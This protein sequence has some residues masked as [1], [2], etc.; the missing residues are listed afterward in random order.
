MLEFENPA[1]IQAIAAL[2]DLT[3]IY[4]CGELDRQV[5]QSERRRLLSE[6]KPAHPAAHSL[7]HYFGDI[8]TVDEAYDGTELVDAEFAT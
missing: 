2:K 8:D 6:L 5:F 3:C 7:S 1:A 4:L